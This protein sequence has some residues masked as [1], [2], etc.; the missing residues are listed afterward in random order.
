MLHVGNKPAA[1]TISFGTHKYRAMHI[2]VIDLAFEKN[3]PGVTL[4]EETIKNSIHNEDEILDFL[5]PSDDYKKIWCDQT[6]KVEDY[7]LSTNTAGELYTKLILKGIR[8]SG[9]TLLKTMPS[10]VRHNL[11]KV[12]AA[13]IWKVKK[14]LT[15]FIKSNVSS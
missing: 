2:N 3:S 6:Q 9:K 11:S 14:Q 15:F 10:P 8:H 5:A 4:L 12:I 1:I 7:T 13:L